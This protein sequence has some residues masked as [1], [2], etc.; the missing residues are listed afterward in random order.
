[1]RELRDGTMIDY[2][3]H[4]E[5]YWIPGIGH[6]KLGELRPRHVTDVLASRRRRQKEIDEAAEKK[7]AGAAEAAGGG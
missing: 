3:R 7:A 6:L 4:V 5:A 2:R 1:V